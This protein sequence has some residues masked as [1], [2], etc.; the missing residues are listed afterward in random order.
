MNTGTERPLLRD[1][2]ADILPLLQCETFD[3]SLEMLHTVM[4]ITFAGVCLFIGRILTRQ[5]I[6]TRR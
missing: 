3:M 6:R 4:I 1:G 2:S 5:P